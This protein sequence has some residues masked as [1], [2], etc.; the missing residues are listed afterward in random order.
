MQFDCEGGRRWHKE[1]ERKAPDDDNGGWV[2][3]K[4]VGLFKHVDPVYG[5]Q[6][7]S[8]FKATMTAG[9][10]LQTKRGKLRRMR[11]WQRRS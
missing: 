2:R 9:R 11:W 7:Q 1:P 3:P 5:E 6:H 8:A 4:E 10:E